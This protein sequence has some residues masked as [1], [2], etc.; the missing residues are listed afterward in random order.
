MA[1]IEEKRVTND[2]RVVLELKD[3]HKG[4]DY[5]GKATNGTSNHKVLNGINL[6]VKKGEFIT[7]VGP[8]GCG[9]STLLNIICGL[10]QPDSGE[11]HVE[12]NGG[13][14]T[15]G[16]GVIVIFQ[17]GAL[18]PWLTVQ[19]NIEFGLKMAN[20]EKSK[21]AETASR[22]IE[23]VGLSRFSQSYVYQL[24]GGMKQRVAIARALAI[25]PDVLL[26]DEPFAA[27]DVQTRELMYDELLAIHKTTGKTIIFVTHNIQ[28]ALLLG[29]RVI[30]LS[31]LVRNIKREFSIELQRPRL[32]DAPELQV[33]KRQILK[34]FEEDFRHAK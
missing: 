2:P 8:S 28:E 34:E 27:L 14:K 16:N 10:D 12:R 26:M 5:N 29:D 31:P 11:V 9:K 18:F 25:D 33:I 20:V 4:F 23:M 3:V 17:E 30:V 19:D 15:S 22:F 32:A 6:K 21:R 7:V 24:S 1:L 13:V